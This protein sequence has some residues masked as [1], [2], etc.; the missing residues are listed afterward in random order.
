MRLLFIVLMFISIDTIS[1]EDNK[2]NPSIYVEQWDDIEDPGVSIFT[3]KEFE[4][5][6]VSDLSLVL[7]F[8]ADSYLIVPINTTLNPYTKKLKIDLKKYNA[9]YIY[10][11]DDLLNSAELMLTYD[12]EY[13]EG[14][15]M[16]SCGSLTRKYKLKELIHE[17]T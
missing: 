13:K 4:S 16:L 1:C 6:V 12:Y 9:S 2:P 11:T 7:K 3:Q 17:K 8:S 14:E 5:R 10:L 15:P